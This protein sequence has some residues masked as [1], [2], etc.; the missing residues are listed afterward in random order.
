MYRKLRRL[1]VFPQPIGK[2]NLIGALVI[3]VNEIGI[4]ILHA[5]NNDLGVPGLHIGNLI[6]FSIFRNQL[7]SFKSK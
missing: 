6:I 1:N 2:P 4:G 3:S 7:N 5:L